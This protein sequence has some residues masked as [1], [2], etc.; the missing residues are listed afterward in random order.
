MRVIETLSYIVHI[1]RLYKFI[2]TFLLI[3]YVRI[4][5]TVSPGNLVFRRRIHHSV[6]LNRQNSIYWM[7]I[8]VCYYAAIKSNSC[9]SVSTCAFKAITFGQSMSKDEMVTLLFPFNK[10]IIN[11][12]M[13]RLS[14]NILVYLHYLCNQNLSSP[15]F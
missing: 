14:A 9:T 10:L 8:I 7:T 3:L 12:L 13:C 1:N 6:F 15:V 11:Y 4:G 2:I 5:S